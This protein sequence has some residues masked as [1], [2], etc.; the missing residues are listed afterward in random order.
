MPHP[1]VQAIDYEWVWSSGNYEIQV[2]AVTDVELNPNAPNF[3]RRLIDEVMVS[4]S[5][6]PA[7]SR[8]NVR[9]VILART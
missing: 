2:R 4:V 5:R 6:E 8:G 9:K 7:S 1:R 3:D